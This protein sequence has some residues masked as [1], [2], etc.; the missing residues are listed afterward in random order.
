[1][2][3]NYGVV[4]VTTSSQQEAEQIAS[5]LVDSK[6]AAC[7]SMF[8]MRSIYTWQGEVHNEQEW[9]LLIKTDLGLFPTLETK[10][11]ELHSYEVPEIIAL[12][13]LAGSK[14][15]LGWIGEQVMAND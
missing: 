7:V 2:T 3:S 15:Y 9:Q 5:A 11:K 14:S 13:I 6:L 1:M 4:L 10:I 8:P 12:P